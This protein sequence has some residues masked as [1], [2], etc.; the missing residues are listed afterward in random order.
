MDC[1]L[2]HWLWTREQR[3]QIIIRADA[4]FGTD[5]NVRYI[6]WLG[7]QV[8]VKGYS[9]RRTQAWLKQIADTDWCTDPDNPDRWAA[10]AP[11]TLRLGRRLQAY[12]LR[13]RNQRGA[14]DHATLLTTLQDPIFQQW[15]MYDGRGAMEDEIRADKSGLDLCHRRKHSLNALEGWLV[16][17]D[18]AHNLLAWLHP[19]MLSGSSFEGY[20]PQ[21]IVRD[22]MSIPGHLTFEGDRLSKVAL[23]TSHPFADKMRSCLHK[24]L[25]MFDLA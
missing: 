8:L 23:L 10:V 12:V 3:R 11:V 16:L 17:T 20:G 9:G 14:L 15:R 5:A 1:L 22:L 6:L 4:E 13:W 25:V 2:K 7:F 18:V 21:R 19:W 24:L